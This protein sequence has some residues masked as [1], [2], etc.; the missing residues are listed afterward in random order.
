MGSCNYHNI[1]KSK[2][3]SLQS[4][5]QCKVKASDLGFYASFDINN[6]KKCDFSL[7]SMIPSMDKDI[8]TMAGRSDHHK[9][10]LTQ[11]QH[12]ASLLLLI[13]GDIATNPGPIKFPCGSCKKPVRSNQKGIQCED[14]DFWFHLKCIDLPIKEYTRLSDSTDSWFCRLCTL[15]NFT[16]SFFEIQHEN[17]NR[18]FSIDNDDEFDRSYLPSDQTTT[19]G[20]NIS[21]REDEINLFEELKQVRK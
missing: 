12:V 21:T 5:H 20:V 13:S 11:L 2:P 18:N 1:F 9:H 15:P 4:Y 8:K 7:Q 16:D 19:T 6:L 10:L 3:R 14:C 17:E